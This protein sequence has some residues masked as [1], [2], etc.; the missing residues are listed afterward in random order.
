LIA[1]TRFLRHG[2]GIDLWPTY[3]AAL[4]RIDND[5]SAIESACEAARAAFGHFN[6]SYGEFSVAC[7]FTKDIKAGPAT[8]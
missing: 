8:M 2:A 3:T 7:P 6:A 4:S 5:P 1:A